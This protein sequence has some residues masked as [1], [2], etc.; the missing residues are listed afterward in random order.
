MST[1][2]SDNESMISLTPKPS[3]SFF[4]DRIRWK[5]TIF[6]EKKNCFLWENGSG[7]LNQKRKEGFLTAFTPVDLEGTYNVNK[8]AS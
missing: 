5:E 2:T 8:K 1:K 4:V 3:Q 7:W 6:T